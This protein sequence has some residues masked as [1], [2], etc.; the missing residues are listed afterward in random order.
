MY[1]VILFFDR[2]EKE[3]DLIISACDYLCIEIFYSLA[4]ISNMKCFY[5]IKVKFTKN[6]LFPIVY[7]CSKS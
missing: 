4:L 1:E 3:N 7:R 6:I 5:T 2:L